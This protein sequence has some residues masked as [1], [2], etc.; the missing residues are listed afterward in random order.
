MWS[1]IIEEIQKQQQAAKAN[2]YTLWFRGQRD[3][4][5]PL[6]SSIHR[7]VIDSYEAVLGASSQANPEAEKVQLLREAYKSLFHRFKARAIGL[8]AEHERTDWGL[9]F[10]MQHLGLPTRLLDWTESFPCALYFAQWKR[11]PSDDAAIFM[12][13][14]EQH[15]RAVIGSEG[16]VSLG[17]DAARKTTVETHFYHPGVF[18]NGD[19]M[20]TLAVEPE[21]T[22]SRM[23]AQRSAFTLCGASFQPLEQKYSRVIKRIVLP[24]TDFAETQA[25]LDLAGQTHFGYFPDLEGLRDH[26]IAG[27]DLEITLAKEYRTKNQQ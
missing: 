22:N 17:G 27:M 16:L 24:T 20:E 1:E 3:A 7:R 25:F 26:L 12:F 13:T 5:W 23:V 9:V 19:D 21:L 18:C 10:A 15:N 8:L 6:R 11:R 2:G 4:S 14:P